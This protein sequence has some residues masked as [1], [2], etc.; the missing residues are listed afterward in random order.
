MRR[1]CLHAMLC[2]RSARGPSSD[3][4]RLAMRRRSSMPSKSSTCMPLLSCVERSSSAAIDGG[5]TLEIP[6]DGSSVRMM[7]RGGQSSKSSCVKP[8]VHQTQAHARGVCRRSSSN[9]HADACVTSVCSGT[10]LFKS[11]QQTAAGHACAQV[12][13]YVRTS[14]TVFLG[15]SSSTSTTISTMKRSSSNSTHAMNHE[16]RRCR[17][18]K[19]GTYCVGTP[20]R[21]AQL[22]LRVTCA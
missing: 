9:T 22:A 17:F 16:R 15:R 2:E 5:S 13:E 20:R 19:R 21:T 10:M 6:R 12:S 14:Y 1:A 3:T 4:S 18:C 11:K 8:A 7:R